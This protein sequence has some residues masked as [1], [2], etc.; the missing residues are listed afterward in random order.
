MSG[1]AP[2]FEALAATAR[3]FWLVPL[4]PLLAA[5]LLA[6][7]LLL[8]RGGGEAG[9]PLTAAVAST[10]ALGALALLLACD[11]AALGGALPE[12]LILG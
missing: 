2:L 8:R 3:A 7:R 6:L 5:A 10:A 11:L 4:L 12:H 1:F 9:E